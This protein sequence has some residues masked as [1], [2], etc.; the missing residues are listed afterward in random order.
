MKQRRACHAGLCRIWV[1]TVLLCISQAWASNAELEEIGRILSRQ[2]WQPPLPH[3]ID[4]LQQLADANTVVLPETL[5]GLLAELDAYTRYFPGTSYTSQ[6]ETVLSRSGVGI[7]LVAENAGIRLDV[8]QGGPAQQAGVPDMALLL[9][10]NERSVQGMSADQVAG[11]FSGK[12]GTAVK[13]A[14]QDAA[15]G[16]LA[17]SLIR[18]QFTPLL[19]EHRRQAGLQVL[20]IRYFLASSTRAALQAT[21][22]RLSTDG[23]LV[24]DLRGNPGGDLYEALDVAGEFLPAGSLLANLHARNVEPRPIRSTGGHRLNVPLWLLVDDETASAAE[25][26]AG[27]LQAHGRARV[28][29]ISTYGKCSSQADA[30]LSTGAVLRYT[31]LDVALPDGRHCNGSGIVPDIHVGQGAIHDLAALLHHIPHN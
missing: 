1:C 7:R 4:Q 17:K 20:R 14:Y 31:N 30:R 2:L 21:L 13:I 15:G 8:L 27:I 22:E 19:V 29:G 3:I 10:V 11:L 24:L 26:F 18:Q 23:P 28:I 5:N 16:R 9:A 25:I 6:A 12:T